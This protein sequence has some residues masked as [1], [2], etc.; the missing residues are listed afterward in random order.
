MLKLLFHCSKL[1]LFCNIIFL[2]VHFIDYM[3]WQCCDCCL[4][5]TK[6]TWWGPRKHHVLAYLVLS[7]VKN[8]QWCLAYRCWN[9]ISSSGLSL[10]SHLLLEYT[11]VL[12]M[13]LH[14]HYKNVD[15]R[16]LIKLWF[17]ETAQL[18]RIL[19]SP[20]TFLHWSYLTC[21]CTDLRGWWWIYR[22][23]GSWGSNGCCLRP[24]FTFHNTKSKNFY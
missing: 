2:W 22:R 7:L 3:F 20:L 8:A 10:G 18:P 1:F 6:T 5:G 21:I 9:A 23:G 14:T 13:W 24:C 4:V 12:W 17:V 16:N 19:S 15:M 11:H